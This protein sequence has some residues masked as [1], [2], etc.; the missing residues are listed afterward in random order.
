MND[1]LAPQ[2]TVVIPTFHD[3]DRLGLCLAALAQ[4]SL[5]AEAFEI[6]VANNDPADQPPQDLQLQDNTQIIAAPEPGSYAAR[7]AA[8]AVARAPLIAFTDSDCIP[9]VDWLKNAVTYL[10][11]NDD[12]GVIAG[13]IKLF[14][15]GE[16]PTLVE[17]YDSIFFLRQD[18]YVAQ[19]FGAT[20]NVITRRKI[21]D[22]VGPFDASMM[23]G[24]DKEW[25]M[26]AVSAGHRLVY[27]ADIRVGHPARDKL[28]A[29]LKKARRLAGGIHAKKINAGKR[30]IIP[31]FDRLIPS[32]R[33]ARKIHAID[34]VGF[35]DGMGVWGIHYLSRVTM[36]FEQIRLLLPWAK[37]QT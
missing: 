1:V 5:P 15:R 26:R 31:Q 21:I 13:A 9:D 17:R 18:S 28:S 33:I 3:W 29:V 24:G 27:G 11:D 37:Y 19:G 25:T 35:W 2:I 30:F 22:Q 4:Q 20:A 6:V 14:W 10:A 32:V 23:S 12:V 7:N 36:L 16:K 8:L 34:D